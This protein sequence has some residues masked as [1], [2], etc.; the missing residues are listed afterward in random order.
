MFSGGQFLLQLKE[1]QYAYH[2]TTSLLLQDDPVIK[3]TD[4]ILIKIP[5]SEVHAHCLQF[6]AFTWTADTQLSQFEN[7]FKL[8]R[9]GSNKWARRDSWAFAG[10]C[11]SCQEQTGRSVQSHYRS[12]ENWS[13][14]TIL[15]TKLCLPWS[16]QHTRYNYRGRRMVSTHQMWIQLQ[17]LLTCIISKIH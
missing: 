2:F 5:P 12:Y 8:H 13:R 4:L 6:K 16:I 7:S 10:H 15:S 17:H 3:S 1:M 14:K 11:R 9:V